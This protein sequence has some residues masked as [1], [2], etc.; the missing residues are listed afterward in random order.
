MIHCSEHY[1]QKE[2]D[3]LEKIRIEE[4]EKK[5][6]EEEAAAL[7]LQQEE[8]AKNAKKNP[9]P[10]KRNSLIINPPAQSQPEQP[11]GEEQPQGADRAEGEEEKKEENPEEVKVEEKKKKYDP[12]V[13]DYDTFELVDYGEKTYEN[14]ISSINTMNG[15][16]W[17]GRLSP[18]KLENLFDNY[19]KIIEAIHNRKK[20]LKEKFEED[21]A[22]QE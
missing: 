6:A 14:L 15:V 17:L 20:V 4:E 16:M 18:S 13:Y 21:Q 5:K 22:T 19:P 3:R 11:Q 7:A 12:R 1:I 2:N 10:S 9:I 8:E